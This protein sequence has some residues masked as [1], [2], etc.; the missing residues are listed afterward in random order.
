MH[1][2]TDEQLEGMLVAIISDGLNRAL[3]ALEA[4]G[5]VDKKESPESLQGR[6]QQVS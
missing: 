6:W 1:V 2:P 5:A 4:A 3:G